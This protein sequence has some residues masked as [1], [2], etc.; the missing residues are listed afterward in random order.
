MTE[1]AKSKVTKAQLI[2]DIKAVAGTDKAITRA[3]YLLGGKFKK[4]YETLF[5]TFED[6]RAA[7]GLAAPIIEKAPESTPES[8]VVEDETKMVITLPKTDISTYA[9]LVHRFQ[10]DPSVWE[11]TRFNS[12]FIEEKEN[13]VVAFLKKRVDILAI[14][15]EIEDLKALAASNAVPQVR[16]SSQHA[17]TGNLLEVNIPDVHFGK[18]AWPE[19]TGYEP[20][21]IKIAP[22]MYDRAV[23]ALIARNADT[24][25]D[26]VVY[27]IGNDAL[28]ADDLEGRTTSGTQVTN[29]ARYHK[30]FS[31]TRN[32]H[33]RTVEKLRKIAPVKVIVVYG[34]HDQLSAWHLGDSMQSY[35]HAYADVTI[36]NVP[37]QRKYHEFGAVMLG[38]THG[39]KGDRSDYPLLMATEEPAMFGR[40]KF[41]EM[42]TGHNHKTQLDE[43]H[44]VRVRIL[45]ALCPADDWH[46][47]LG[48]VGNL[49]NAETYTW[50]KVHGLM[51]I[52]IFNDQS[53]P[54]IET[55][56]DVVIGK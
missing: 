39:D 17:I 27:V 35:F 25:F 53:Q 13:R 33:I 41:R 52:E 7:A 3:Q 26:E 43:K 5:L 11:V 40:T 4:A 23:D 30:V 45:A 19:E 32:T 24:K 54:L 28:N 31:V 2:A 56:A 50:H 49:R 1:M 6:F 18:L 46:S 42:H 44:G 10:I 12:T 22:V 14:K 47:E 51:R 15:A 37:R 34:N 21:D 8:T 16:A 36:D 48:Y 38:F 29:D 20:Y 55:V 9:E